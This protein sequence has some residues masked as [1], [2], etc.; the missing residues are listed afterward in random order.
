[1]FVIRRYAC[2]ACGKEYINKSSLK[3]HVEIKHLMLRV[4]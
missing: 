2:I 3:K 1:M 4:F